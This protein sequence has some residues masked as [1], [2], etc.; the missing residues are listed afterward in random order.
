MSATRIL[1]GQILVVF[2]VVLVTV[3]TATQWTA[4]RLGYQPQLGQ[5]WFEL[6]HGIPVYFLSGGGTPMM[7]T[8]PVCSSKGHAS[9]PRM[10]LFQ[11]LT[12]VVLG[13][14]PVLTTERVMR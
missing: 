6:T 9:Q 7:P 11:L 12:A 4:W 5:P 8:H 10:R 1:W 3:W 14:A 13:L 2:T